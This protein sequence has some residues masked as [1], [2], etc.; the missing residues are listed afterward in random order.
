[1]V[2]VVV[3]LSGSVLL[4]YYLEPDV[5]PT[6][7][8]GFARKLKSPETPGFRRTRPPTHGQPTWWLVVMVVVEEEEEE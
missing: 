6:A 2:V 8:T 4:S 5:I 3:L 7:R 1:M